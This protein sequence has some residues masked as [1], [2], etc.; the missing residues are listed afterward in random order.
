M[1]L[2]TPL[3]IA[4]VGT[5][6]DTMYSGGRY[7]ALILAYAL[8]RTGAQVTF[9]TN[10]RPR[11]VDDLDGLAAGAIDYVFTPDFEHSMPDGAFDYVMLV[12]TGIFL[13]RF[14]EAA[15]AFARRAQ[16]RMALINFEAGNW[17]NAVAP[18]KRDPR[19]WD[20]WRRAVAT[21]GLVL[22]SLRV[23]DGHARD[24]YSAIDPATLRFEVCGPPINSVAADAA[25]D[26]AKD[27]SVVAFVRSTD[28]HKGGGDLLR[29][30]PAILSGRTLRI[31]AGGDH[32]P[33]FRAALEQHY[34]PAGVTLE[35]HSAVSDAAKF[36]FIG[37]AQ[38][39]LF[40]SRFEGFGYPPVEAA[41]MGTETVCYDLPALAETVGGVAHSAP[42]DDVAAFGE[43]LVEALARPE[44]REGLHEAVADLVDIDR[45]GQRIADILLRSLDSVP[46][47]PDI[48]GTA[49]WG[50]FESDT[51]DPAAP[52]L[53]LL[54]PVLA[55]FRRTG[56]DQYLLSV[57]LGCVDAPA[58][59][60]LEGIE[61]GL[62]DVCIVQHG[63][64][65]SITG[66]LSIRPNPD[67]PLTLSL[68]DGAGVTFQSVSLKLTEP[69]PG[70]R[71]TVK[72]SD[73]RTDAQGSD[74]RFE[75]VSS[76]D[77]GLV[78]ILISGDGDNWVEA[79]AQ[80]G[81]I[82]VRLDGVDP[83]AGGLRLY[84]FH[85]G[86]VIDY[87]SGC[88]P[89][90]GPEPV[91]DIER[92]LRNCR[93]DIL[94]FTDFTWDRGVLRVSDQ[95]GTAVIA[96]L[97][98]ARM[99][100][101]GDAVRLGS[102]RLATIAQVI[103]KDRIIHLHFAEGVDP[104]TDAWPAC[105][106]VVA[107]AA[108]AAEAE[109]AL[110]WNDGVWTDQGPF[111]G[112]CI[113]L[114]DEAIAACGADLAILDAQGREI[115]VERIG[116][117][118]SHHVAWLASPIGADAPGP[119]VRASR[120]AGLTILPREAESGGPSTPE[121]I[122]ADAGGRMLRMPPGAQLNAGDIL[123]F[124]NSD[125]RIVQAVDQDADGVWI[126]LDLAVP[127]PS[128]IRFATVEEQL[129]F[130]ARQ[131][132]R[133][134]LTPAPGHGRLAPLLE[135]YRRTQ[136]PVAA[137]PVDD[138]PRVLFAS[139]VPPDPADQGNRIVT[140]NLIRHLVSLGFDVDLLLLGQV[141]PERI[142]QEFGD[143]VRVFLWSFPQWTAE[144][145]VPVRR[146]IVEELR[147]AP[148]EVASSP[149]FRKLLRDAMTYHP[150]FIVPDALIRV[151]RALYR[152]HY[153]HSIVCNYTHMVRV[154]YELA[155]IRSLPPVAIVTHDALSRLPLE[156][157]G[158]PLDT[159]Y[160]LCSPEMERDVLDVVPGAVVLAI[161]E[162]ECA[163]FRD[164][165]VRNPVELCEY[166]G[167]LE[168]DRYRVVPSAF[169]GRRLLFHASGN[170]MNK[171]AIDWFVKHCWPEVRRAVPDATLVLCGAIS[172]HVGG[173]PGLETHG[174]V[175][176]DRMMELLGTSAVAINPT[177]A[178]TGL[179]IKTV[180]AICAGVPSV[181]LPAAVE[182]LEDMADRFC[183]LER[184]PEGFA[185]A[186]I[187][188]LTDH[189]H[190]SAMRASALALAAERFSESTIYGPLDR[191]MGW[192]QGIGERHATPRAPYGFDRGEDVGAIVAGLPE[193]QGGAR[194][195]L[196]SLLSMGEAGMASRLL[197]RQADVH[198]AD[199][200]LALAAEDLQDAE[201]QTLCA[202]ASDPADLP[203]LARLIDI[204][205]KR[206]DPLLAREAWEHLALAAPGASETI[207]LTDLPDLAL[208]QERAATWQTRPLRVVTGGANPTAALVPPGE[209]MGPGW[210]H[211]EHWGSWSDGPYARLHLVFDPVATA[212]SFRLFGN[213][214]VAGQQ[215]LRFVRLIADGQ[216]VAAYALPIH[217]THFEMTFDLPAPEDGERSELLI[218]IVIDN[219]TP[220][221]LED[222]KVADARQLGI[223]LHS[224]DIT[225]KTGK[226]GKTKS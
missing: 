186:C 69:A 77:A 142:Y 192:D 53:S 198:P 35:F 216:G 57:R 70:T 221:R 74:L 201:H 149:Q 72:M 39:L 129:D 98:P 108:P 121:W 220:Y 204:A 136:L 189:Q 22:S 78:S 5:N 76:E 168:C 182:G 165:G 174:I 36:A 194:E 45:V 41:Y 106:T 18:V 7:H 16:A 226:K 61:D 131:F 155:A 169:A 86:Q 164:I 140:R 23:S 15:F 157:D 19:L 105:L 135:S 215:G 181:C 60:A 80:D 147:A 179:K 17:F 211:M 33:D 12:P 4:V 28:I 73:L 173:V 93:I 47:M 223:G 163:Y 88:P 46:P 213:T 196:S 128:S 214:N 112:R 56:W 224:I 159:T 30:D 127:V 122:A 139:I 113:P 153:Y 160:R 29:I 68:R 111:A 25:R 144:P 96:C 81:S 209:R 58:S 188:L 195:L 104:R 184:E 90:A 67:Q 225:Q 185:A 14:Y 40:P 167:L 13:P 208:Y 59:V 123:I 38:A 152:R 10:K 92:A 145:S 117:G 137:A 109:S 110:V 114:P 210:S 64:S 103:D 199:A 119:F 132:A 63:A 222:G 71:H 49:L 11:F 203:A 125:L 154:A 9:V 133:P 175:S 6:N 115:A 143:R 32:D 31:I 191:H 183:A 62:Q 161:S 42:V 151:A 107:R 48:A 134:S 180:E 97:R 200:E 118:L 102:G 218:E 202:I 177:L 1:R 3:R 158:K 83:Q 85:D 193:A 8:A 99:P 166:D 34:A 87:L 50:P 217:E 51:P 212:L 79:Q 207:A 219:P 141:A 205:V 27:G 126:L 20:Y 176:R 171:A 82:D 65:W 187:R 54:P 148:P 156:T 124:N 130:A 100:E 2:S 91:V 43:A 21:G 37:A 170:P 75:V 26:V 120:N 24:F 66:R 190:W 95:P 138:R 162:S 150:F 178:G 172:F 197:R 44:R 52:A 206:Q 116:A 55:G 89:V 84:L 101:P 94:N 146:K